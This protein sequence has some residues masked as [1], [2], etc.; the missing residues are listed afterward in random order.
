MLSR[1]LTWREWQCLM[2]AAR[3]FTLSE[4]AEAMCLSYDTIKSHRRS[5]LRK[6]EC[7]TITGA[8]LKALQDKNDRTLFLPSALHPAHLKKQA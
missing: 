2:Y 5:I 1:A 4:T 6:L 8:L 7:R 3:D